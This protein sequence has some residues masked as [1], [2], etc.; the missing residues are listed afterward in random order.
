M[1]NCIERVRSC[2]IDVDNLITSVKAIIV[3][4]KTRR[5]LF[6]EIGSPPEPVVN[7][8]GTWIASAEY[9]VENIVQVKEIMNSLSANGI[10]VQKAKE[11]VNYET[12]LASLVKIKSDDSVL[13][14]NIKK[15]ESSKYSI[16]ET[17]GDI[18][19]L[20]FKGDGFQENE[21]EFGCECHRGTLK[22]SS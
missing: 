19:K 2:F 20:D 22:A 3:K 14:T 13:T 7:R 11:A 9:H 1:H 15:M 12:V 6:I 21:Q 17:Y 16:R 4:K 10:L 5:A 8:W 18:N